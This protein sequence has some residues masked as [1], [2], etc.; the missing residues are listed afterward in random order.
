MLSAHW[1]ERKINLTESSRKLVSY[2]MTH[3]HVI[4]IALQ[5]RILRALA[6]AM[7]II[8]CPVFFQEKGNISGNNHD[9]NFKEADESP[10][11]KWNR[12]LTITQKKAVTCNFASGKNTIHKNI[13]LLLRLQFHP[14]YSSFNCVLLQIVKPI[15]SNWNLS[16]NAQASQDKSQWHP[17]LKLPTNHTS[18]LLYCRLMCVHRLFFWHGK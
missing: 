2:T 5:E 12:W 17:L 8:C 9:W 11:Y 3:N 18:L 6:Y 4:Y 15:F 7:N 16:L 10:F 13:K 1:K 14:L